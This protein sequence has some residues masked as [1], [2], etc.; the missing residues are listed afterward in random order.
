[1]FHYEARKS[2]KEMKKRWLMVSKA[3]KLRKGTRSEEKDSV[4]RGGKD[5]RS[6]KIARW[7]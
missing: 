5:S 7:I 1:V 6:D 2:E 3:L 4:V